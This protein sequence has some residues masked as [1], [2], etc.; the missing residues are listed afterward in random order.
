MGKGWLCRIVERLPS[1]EKM[2]DIPEVESNHLTEAC[3]R[4]QSVR[5]ISQLV[6]DMRSHSGAK[7][8]AHVFFRLP[9]AG[10]NH[11]D[12]LDRSHRRRDHD[13]L[14][15]ECKSVCHEPA[16]H[17]IFAANPYTTQYLSPPPRI[18]ILTPSLQTNIDSLA[19]DSS[20][21]P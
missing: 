17:Y 9:H 21:P 14:M 8:V 19:R 6:I 1:I 20:T 13:K 7:G 5:F 4:P 18:L 2:I 3:D 15:H 10:H 11:P 12:S 16:C